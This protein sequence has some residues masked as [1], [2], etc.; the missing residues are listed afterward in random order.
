[1]RIILKVTAGPLAGRLFHFSGHD[2]FLVGRSKHTHF[3]LPPS[4]RTCSRIHF[5]IE[6]NPPYCRLMDMGSNNGTYVN[7]QRVTLAELKHGDKIRAGRNILRVGVLVPK[8]AESKPSATAD[9]PLTPS[10]VAALPEAIPLSYVPSGAASPPLGIPVPMSPPTA[11]L[12]HSA[13]P[14][15]LAAEPKSPPAAP[16]VA[17]SPDVAPPLSSL[18][19]TLLPPASAPLPPTVA[20]VVASQTESAA[21]RLTQP[22]R[23]PVTTSDAATNPVSRAT[24]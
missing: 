21:A 5:M 4:D 13:P 24:C 16:P 9:P 2:T 11:H 19:R 12:R 8:Q 23:P 17:S 22:D 10:M 1:M 20:H 6:V 3:R 7:G 15:P 14:P 18:C